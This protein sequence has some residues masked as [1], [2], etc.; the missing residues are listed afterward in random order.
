[1]YFYITDVVQVF[2]HL[3]FCLITFAD[4]VMVLVTQLDKFFN[5][6]NKMAESSLVKMHIIKVTVCYFPSRGKM[7]KTEQC[8]G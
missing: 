3:L 5:Y 6:G 1:M 4:I 2:P 7:L 8:H